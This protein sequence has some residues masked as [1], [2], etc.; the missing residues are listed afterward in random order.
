VLA[1]GPQSAIGRMGPL[2]SPYLPEDA[3]RPAIEEWTRPERVASFFAGLGE[4]STVMPSVDLRRPSLDVAVE[5]LTTL[6]TGWVLIRSM[7]D[8]TVGAG[9]W[10]R[11][12]YS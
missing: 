2:A 4:V 8:A 5:E 10:E 3:K 12:A 1:W 7:L 9:C 11:F 6:V